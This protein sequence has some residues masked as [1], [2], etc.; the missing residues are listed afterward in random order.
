MPEIRTVVPDE[1]DAYLDALV[2]KGIFANKAEFVRA[3]LLAYVSATG[4]FFKGFDTENI[5]T[6]NGRLYQ[7]EYAR[8]AGT[9]G[10]T[11]VGVVCE[12][13]VL[14]ATEALTR[15]RLATGVGKILRAGDRLAMAYSGLVADAW[16]VF[17]ELKTAG[18]KSTD[19]AVRVVRTVLH[20]HTL[21]RTRRP[22]GVVVL[23]ASALDRKPRLVEFDSSGTAVESLGVAVGRGAVAASDALEARY[24]KMRLSDAEKLLPEI[25]GR[26]TEVEVAR[27]QG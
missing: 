23:L 24:R 2:R 27:V 6:P 26:G 22:L 17:D 11:A 10:L 14:L 1:V 20:R 4:T 3:A 19:D 15:S 5:F 8:E 13:G 7:V 12:D 16:L 9:R 18:P 21:D 25:F